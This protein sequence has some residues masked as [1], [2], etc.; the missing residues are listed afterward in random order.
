MGN[1]ATLNRNP[2]EQLMTEP[3]GDLERFIT[4]V[5]S[6]EGKAVLQ[7]SFGPVK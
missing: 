3:K 4:L 2:K 5:K 6:T 1:S 7:K